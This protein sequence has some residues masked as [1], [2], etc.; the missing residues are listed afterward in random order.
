MATATISGIYE[1]VNIMTGERYIGS[2]KNIAARWREHRRALH[3]D[4]HHSFLLQQAW[5]QCGPVGFE[6]RI[7]EICE[8]AALLE[9]EQ[10]FFDTLN[11]AYNI[12]KQAGVRGPMSEFGRDKIAESNKRRTGWKMS[13]EGKARISRANKGNRST[14]G[15]KRD[16]EA[17]AKTAAA[18]RGR[19][20]TLETRAKIAAAL[21]GSVKPP[22]T[23]EY[24]AKISAAHKGRAKSP[25]H[26]AE[27]QAGRRRRVYTE[28]VRARIGEASKLAWERRKKVAP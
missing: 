23:A 12:A 21:H 10:S 3:K 2:T 6:F 19:K 17:V 7:L 9:R 22:R 25:E 1:I 18:H 15:Q 24:R 5:N 28:E 27:L 26:M 4:K 16:P 13:D 14:K 11:P 20:R 8:T